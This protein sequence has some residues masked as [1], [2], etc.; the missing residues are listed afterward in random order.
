MLR[1]QKLRRWQRNENIVSGYRPD[2]IVVYFKGPY[3]HC[4]VDTEKQYKDS[5]QQHKKTEQQHQDT[6][7]QYKDNK[8]QYKD[9]KE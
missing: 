5:E 6:E 4:F 2:D 8:E 3:R 7:E 9:N 1:F